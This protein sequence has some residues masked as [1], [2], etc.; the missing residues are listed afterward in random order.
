MQKQGS[1]SETTKRPNIIPLYSDSHRYNAM[2]CAGNAAIQTPNLD[3]MD[4]GRIIERNV[5]SICYRTYST[6]K[7][8]EDT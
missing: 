7:Y 6:I 8:E 2:G 3:R 1:R 5:I 4:R